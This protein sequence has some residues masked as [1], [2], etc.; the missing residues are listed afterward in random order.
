MSKET[1]VGIVLGSKT[2]LPSMQGARDVLRDFGVAHTLTIAS[3]HRGPDEVREYALTAEDRGLMIIIAAAGGSAAL[4]GVI[5]AY[6]RLPVIGVPIKTESLQGLD[7][8]YSMV[9]MPPGIPVAVVAIN[10]AKNAGLLAIEI[11]ALQDPA[12]KEKITTH[13]QDLRNQIALDN[14]DNKYDFSG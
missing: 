8:L 11:L 12:L 4:P 7:S 3:A 9:Q 1:R 10:G 2:D 5:A 13:R 6:T 14:K